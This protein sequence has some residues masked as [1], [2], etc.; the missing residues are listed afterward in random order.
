MHADTTGRRT[1]GVAVCVPPELELSRLGR[2]VIDDAAEQRRQKE[3]CSAAGQR[4]V[5]LISGS[6]A[7]D[8]G[9]GTCLKIDRQQQSIG[10]L[11]PQDRRRQRHWWNV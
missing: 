2:R 9:V 6:L 8:L 10:S 5:T 4:A 1:G 7:P 3:F 11:R